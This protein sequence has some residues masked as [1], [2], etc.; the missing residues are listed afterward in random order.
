MN[1][2]IIQNYTKASVWLK[3]YIRNK[4]LQLL[5]VLIS[6]TGVIWVVR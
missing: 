3:N 1:I 6:T 2:Y 5:L 4:K